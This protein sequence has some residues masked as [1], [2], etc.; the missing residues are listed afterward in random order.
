M[1]VTCVYVHVKPDAINSFINATISNHQASVR[2]PGNLRFD[3]LR[4]ADNPFRFMIYEAYESEETAAAHKNSAHYLKWRDDV[5][6]MMAE[7]RQ[8]VKYTILE[9]SDSTKW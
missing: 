3:F 7:P 4:Q 5:K 6:E 1:I 8:G 9:P 2:E